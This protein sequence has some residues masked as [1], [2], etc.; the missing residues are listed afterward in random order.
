MANIC[1]L[2]DAW[3]PKFGGINSFNYDFC[4]ALAR[5]C[6]DAHKV[7]CVAPDISRREIAVA[8][9]QKLQLV[10]IAKVDLGDP[11]AIYQS[12][13]QN[14]DENQVVWVGHDIIT[15]EAALR[16]KQNYG[17]TSIV[18]HHMAYEEYYGILNPDPAAV[19][20]K[21]DTQ[22][23]IL[24]RADIVFAVGPILF[25]SAQD[26]CDEP[27]KCF[28]IDPGFARNSHLRKNPLNSFHGVV[29]GRVEK[30]N[31]VI[32]QTQLAI[33]AVAK[34]YEEDCTAGGHLFGGNKKPK[35]SI[36][37]YQSSESLQAV[38]EEINGCYKGYTQAALSITPQHYLEDR[39]SLFDELKNYS[40]A[41]MLSSHEGFGLVGYE[42]ISAGIP[43]IISQS[44]GLYRFLQ[45][46]KLDGYAQSIP[47]QGSKN[48]A[49]FT[50][51]DLNRTVH[52]IQQLRRDYQ[53]M[54]GLA[55]TLHGIISKDGKYSWDHCAETFLEKISLLHP[56]PSPAVTGT[57]KAVDGEPDLDGRWVGTLTRDGQGHDFVLEIDHTPSDIIC[58]AFSHHSTSISEIGNLAFDEEANA[59]KLHFTWKCTST[60]LSV[61]NANFKGT[62]EVHIFPEVT[63]EGVRVDRMEGSYYSDRKPKSTRGMLQLRY[64]G[65]QKYNTFRS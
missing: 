56:T 14:W 60:N 28:R 42:A 50:E 17:G 39:A 65:S 10:N 8:G 27:E 49:G 16:C 46:N 64:G 19:K 58:K 1:M 21:V 7:F 22:N 62:T 55:R 54:F 9:E 53:A 59:W 20:R 6:K 61:G 41:M 48:G 29:F 12:L 4:L 15:G 44:S 37:G 30:G 34:A 2:A 57:G 47:V 3:G 40:F 23:K 33:A 13:G 5:V 36:I 43:V 52:E 26:I 11:N 18:F 25:E 38:Q 45:E 51:Q 63:D 31:T 35:L 32:K 24:S